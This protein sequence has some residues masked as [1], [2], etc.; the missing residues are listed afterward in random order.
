MNQVV[1]A[2]PSETT[3]IRAKD[4]MNITGCKERFAFELLSDIKKAYKVK[5]VFY[6]HVKRYLSLP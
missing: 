3:L 5:W 6:H 1:T 2:S 4:L